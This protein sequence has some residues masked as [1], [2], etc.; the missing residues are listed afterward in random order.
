MDHD[1]QPWLI[2]HLQRLRY[3]ITDNFFIRFQRMT[4]NLPSH[5]SESRVRPRIRNSADCLH[6]RL[7]VLPSTPKPQPNVKFLQHTTL[8]LIGVNADVQWHRIRSLG[9]REAHLE[10][11]LWHHPPF[12]CQC[13]LSV[14]HHQL[15]RTC[16]LRIL[17]LVSWNSIH[18][19]RSD[20]PEL[21]GDVTAPLI[22]QHGVVKDGSISQ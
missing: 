8:P 13:A 15:T 7:R 21:S 1:F 22:R 19:R 17:H 2:Q 14:F 9:S 10:S 6:T 3:R 18:C 5:R 20:C 16:I 4:C 12:H 11:S